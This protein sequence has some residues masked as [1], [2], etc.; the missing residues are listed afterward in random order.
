MGEIF[1]KA[2]CYISVIALGVVLR[3]EG[4]FKR[5]DFYLLSRIVMKITTPAAIVTSMA[6]R[7]LA[8][9]MLAISLMGLGFGVLYIAIAFLIGAGAGRDKLAFYIQNLPGYNIGNF[10]LPFAQGFLGPLGVTATSLFDLGNVVIAMGGSYSVA[11]TVQ[12]GRVDLKRMGRTLMSS[13]PLIAHL[14]MVT[15][16]LLHWK[17]PGPVVSFASLIGGANA[18]LAMLMVGVGFQL[19]G[20]RSQLKDILRILLT[21]YAVAVVLAVLCFRLLPLEMEY[22]RAVTLLVLSPICTANSAFTADLK[23][24][25]G[26]ASAISS[27]SIPISIAGMVAVLVLTA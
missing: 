20:D 17:V 11:S 7:E 14:V 13:V 24:D 15:L 22:R 27:L 12:G 21:R 1:I 9:S 4:F 2:A 5:E 23:G 18:F 16:A 8:P 3:R 6:G 26:L 10:A 19:S 25:V